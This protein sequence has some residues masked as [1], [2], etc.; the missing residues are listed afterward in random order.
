MP[1]LAQRVHD[2]RKGG[3]HW[4]WLDQRRQIKGEDL[5]RACDWMVAR[6]RGLQI[7]TRHS[8]T[9]VVA[10]GF[11]QCSESM[12]PWSNLVASSCRNQPLK[13]HIVP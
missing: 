8:P 12:I 13:S 10:F 1:A 7:T 5:T 3:V 4:H 6:P 11:S 9:T 2:A